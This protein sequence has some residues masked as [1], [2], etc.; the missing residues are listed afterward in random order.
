MPMIKPRYAIGVVLAIAS[1]LVLLLA[2]DRGTGSSSVEWID[3]TLG[4]QGDNCFR[5][6]TYRDAAGVDHHYT[7]FVPSSRDKGPP[8]VLLFLNGFGKNGN[9]GVGHLIDGIAPVAWD[10]QQSCPLLIVFPQCH[11]DETWEKKETA[12]RAMAILDQTIDEFGGDRERVYL[13]GLSSGAD[14]VWSLALAYRDRFDAIAP[15]SAGRTCDAQRIAATHLPIWTA[16][17]RGDDERL[18]SANRASHRALV[19][20]GADV[21]FTEI[22]GT[23]DVRWNRH[24]AWDFL[25]RNQAF[26]RWMLVQRRH[27]DGRSQPRFENMLPDLSQWRQKGTWRL[28]HGV[29]ALGAADHPDACQLVRENLPADFDLRIEFQAVREAFQWQIFL[30]DGATMLSQPG[31]ALS[32]VSAT[33]GTGGLLSLPDE[34]WLQPIDPSAQHSIRIGKDD[35]NDL[36]L[37]VRGE[38]VE[39]EINA[40]PAI[41]VTRQSIGRVKSSLGLSC[42]LRSPVRWRNV[43]IRT[44]EADR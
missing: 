21:R 1:V 40:W 4:R 44:L 3:R 17:V 35:W 22:D 11:V 13:T 34:T 27:R 30:R 24:D 41:S 28:E 8:P 43:R 31:I 2:L 16:Y 15:I 10:F 9:D 7:V 14:G 19:A 12:A 23:V 33:Q 18:V 29:L 38:S 36:R 42:N 37:T 39:A 20:A 26:Y 5:F 6:R 25:F 32:L